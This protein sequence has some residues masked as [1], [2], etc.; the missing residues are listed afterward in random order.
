MLCTVFFFKDV[1][2]LVKM[3]NKSL[4]NK[5]N[6]KS[7]PVLEDTRRVWQPEKIKALL[8]FKLRQ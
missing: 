1:M 2:A 5:K 6:V 3:D 8:I 4:F 7:L